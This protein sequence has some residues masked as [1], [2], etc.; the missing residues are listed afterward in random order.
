MLIVQNSWAGE[1]SPSLAAQVASLHLGMNGYVIGD[2]LSAEQKQ[3]AA[4]N[5]VN[6]SYAGTYKFSD[7]EIYVVASRADD[8]ILAL[9]QRYE[10]ADM[11]RARNTISGLMGLYG[12]PTTMAHD[13]LIYWAYTSGGK[14]AEETYTSLKDKNET[15]DILATVKFSSAFEIT[16]E[17]PDHEKTGPVYFIV[18]SDPLTQEFINQE[19]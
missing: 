10:E 14:V 5:K 1:Q 16:P 17:N 19:K 12:E 15:I 7:R 2:R 18:A 8:T 3:M 4:D 9:Y 6:D 13:K 11:A